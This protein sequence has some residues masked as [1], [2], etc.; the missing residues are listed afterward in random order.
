MGK[1]RIPIQGRQ[2]AE[3]S[4]FVLFKVDFYVY[5][6]SIEIIMEIIDLEFECA[7]TLVLFKVDFYVYRI[8]IE[9]IMEIIDLEFECAKT[10]LKTN[11]VK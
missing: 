4:A 8:S 6:I 1:K 5:R 10:P 3:L 11:F 7:K 2:G 9:I